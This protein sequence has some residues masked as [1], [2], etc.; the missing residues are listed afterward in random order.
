MRGLRPRTPLSPTIAPRLRARASPSFRP[1]RCAGRRPGFPAD[2]GRERNVADPFE[3]LL[4]KRAI[5]LDEPPRFLVDVEDGG[6]DLFVEPDRAAA[7]RATARLREGEPSAAV[8]SVRAKQEDFDEPV[9]LVAAEEA[10][11]ADLDVVAH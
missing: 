9:P 6:A 5:E 11:R 2:V 1:R 3:Q 7:L 4:G 10:R 8:G